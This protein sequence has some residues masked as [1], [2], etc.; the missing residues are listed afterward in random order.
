MCSAGCVHDATSTCC[1]GER[2]WYTFL[3]TDGSIFFVLHILL[4]NI[5]CRCCI[6]CCAKLLQC[7]ISFCWSFVAIEH[8]F[9][10]LFVCFCLTCSTVIALFSIRQLVVIL[11][12]E[13][14]RQIFSAHL[15]RERICNIIGK[16][17]YFIWNT[18]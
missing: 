8:N 9:V 11:L 6:S 14:K 18:S 5:H 4:I 10:C 7:S 1:S 17:K 13:L 3:H 12:K 2:F 15:H 16:L